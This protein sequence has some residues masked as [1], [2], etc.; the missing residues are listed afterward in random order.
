MQ[1]ELVSL[2]V[3]PFSQRTVITLLEKKLDFALQFLNEGNPPGWFREVSPLGKVPALRVGDRGLFES[4][5]ISDYLDETYPPRLHPEDPLTRAEHRSWI[6]FG[7]GLLVDLAALC[8]AADEDAY[9]A[10]K[11][12]LSG[13]LLRLDEQ[14]SPGPYWAGERFHLV[15]AAYAPFLMRMRILT[16]RRPELAPLMTRRLEAWTDPLLSRSSVSRSV[17]EDFESRYV[18]FFRNKG[19]ILLQG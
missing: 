8:S 16:A 14:L 15:D 7:S 12:V 1:L 4:S 6:A 13:K 17:T 10:A 19:S 3:C 9:K 2:A 11:E 18:A 5:V